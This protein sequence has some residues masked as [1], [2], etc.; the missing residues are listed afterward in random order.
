M[1][2]TCFL[3]SQSRHG[4]NLV[5][6]S[7]PM[8]RSSSRAHVF[9]TVAVLPAMFG[10]WACRALGRLPAPL[11]HPVV[12]RQVP[13]GQSLLVKAALA[14]E[15]QKCQADLAAGNRSPADLGLAQP[16]AGRGS[17][18]TRSSWPRAGAW[19]ALSR[20][21]QG[22]GIS[23]SSAGAST[24]GASSESITHL[25]FCATWAGYPVRGLLR[26]H[27]AIARSQRWAVVEQ[28]RQAAASGSPDRIDY[29]TTPAQI[30]HPSKLQRGKSQVS[31]RDVFRVWKLEIQKPDFSARHAAKAIRLLPKC[32][33]HSFKGEHP[34]LT[35]LLDRTK[36]LL[37][38]GL[39]SGDE[40]A[41]MLGAAAR[42]RTR[43]PQLQAALVPELL[44]VL[45]QVITGMSL[46]SMSKL[47]LA[48]NDL[49]DVAPELSRAL[50]ECLATIAEQVHNVPTDDLPQMVL[51]V[52]SLQAPGS[53]EGAQRGDSEGGAAANAS[54]VVPVS[55]LLTALSV[56]VR[57]RIKDFA[58]PQLASVTW[59]L[60]VGGALGPRVRDS[61]SKVVAE[62]ASTWSR[63]ELDPDL[64][65]IVCAFARAGARDA[66]LQR[67]IARIAL[68]ETLA[69]IDTWGIAAMAWSYEELHQQGDGL[70]DFRRHLAAEVELR[71]LAVDQ[72]KL[73]RL[74]PDGGGDPELAALWR[75]LGSREPKGPVA[76]GWQIAP[77]PMQLIH[78]VAVE[79]E[80]LATSS[81]RSDWADEDQL[82]LAE[83][84]QAEPGARQPL[85]REDDC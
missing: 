48:S 66:R 85:V 33:F 63:K 77:R 49:K 38:Q 58:L 10:G 70:S 62:R 74:G 2:S 6:P 17:L 73:S 78:R 12:T 56:E 19:Y 31:F 41:D 79:E 14:L 36:D 50:P 16:C 13:P 60:V 69:S 29:S 76:G 35:S 9:L 61:I 1:V 26:Q 84:A 23:S 25:A 55:G 47:I 30:L 42:L 39:A 28:D 71:G 83:A 15:S 4:A 22:K 46:E 53:S 43:L 21:S 82:W 18:S 3:Q 8:V 65:R 45:S 24:G 20:R 59:G 68:R 52:A 75:R 54:K 57:R 51:I 11:Y 5:A 27:G 81:L 64:W 7:L 44:A 80:H 37:S 40:V 32:S 34:V 67:T 72:V